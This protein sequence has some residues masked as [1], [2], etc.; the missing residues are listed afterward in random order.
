VIILNNRDLE[1]L[2]RAIKISLADFVT[3]GGGLLVIGGEHNVRVEKQRKQ[4]DPLERALPATLA[5]PRSPEGTC[6]VIV[7]DKSSSMEGR[8]MELARLSA[9]GVVENLRPVDR[10]GVLM[11]DNSFQWA[12]PIRRA[13]DKG[14]I[15]RLISGIVADGGTQIAPALAEAYRRALPVKAT[16]KH[17][18]LLTDGIS[19][20]G[21]S[22]ALAREAANRHVTISTVGLGEDVNK[23]YLQKIAL[24]AEGKA[25]FLSDPSGLAQVLLRDVMEHTGHTAV[26]KPVKPIVARQAEIL[27]GVPMEKAPPLGGYIRFKAKPTAETILKFASKDPL[28]VRWQYGLGRSAV[29]ASDAKSRWAKEWVAW[30]GFDRFWV[31]VVRDLLPHAATSDARLTLDRA[32]GEL[33]AE[34]RLGPDVA[35]PDPLPEIY[36]LGPGEFRKPLNLRKM[37]ARTYRARIPIGS[38]QGLFRV[39]A[40]EN[41]PA[42][43]ETG[44][45]LQEDELND[46]G[47]NETLLQRTAVWTGGRFEPNVRDIFQTGGQAIAT[48]MMLW[49]G[50]LLLAILLNL[51]ELIVRK[52]KGLAG[53]VHRRG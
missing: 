10:V 12:V 43:P 36:V 30:S 53:A 25:Y 24:Y 39:R 46:F 34:Y 35:A 17:I 31:N 26:E 29:F 42:F 45:Y 6:V 22:I 14:L 8:K 1:K 44:I 38:R 49:P 2:S 13:E 18:V 32:T 50:L 21:N 33:V 4:D 9:I 40:V 15:K 20:E 16:Y 23:S 3:A 52:W 5:P 27:D 41:S 51:A 47:A 28:F 7:I 19:E 11:F 48:T 37:A